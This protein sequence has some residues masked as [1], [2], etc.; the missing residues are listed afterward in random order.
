MYILSK[1]EF[2]PKYIRM[3]S[4]KGYD[5]GP[6]GYKTGVRQYDPETG[7]FLSP[8]PFKGYMSD[9]AS[10]HPY[11]YCRGNPIRYSDP[12]GY[13][14]F[15]IYSKPAYE[16]KMHELVARTHA[17]KYKNPVVSQA[18][19][20]EDI[21]KIIGKDYIDTLIIVAHGAPGF[22]FLSMEPGEGNITES[23]IV[24]LNLKFKKHKYIQVKIYACNSARI[25]K[26]FADRFKVKSLGLRTTGEYSGKEKGQPGE[27][28]P[29]IVPEKY[30]GP[31]YMVPAS[32]RIEDFITY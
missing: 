23:D 4:Y 21:K 29:D 25:A 17:R 27:G 30:E 2:N 24:N 5:R 22:L 10:Q 3:A 12:S 14:D 20:I 31:V 8:D 18:S 15:I 9:P 13:K 26:A 19:S 6:F 16:G 32:G 7:R 1:K 11:M 28:L